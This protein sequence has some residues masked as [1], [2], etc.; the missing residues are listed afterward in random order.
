MCVMEQNQTH[1]PFVYSFTHFL[2]KYLEKAK[3][4][5]QASNFKLQLN[6]KNN[7]DSSLFLHI[8]IRVCLSG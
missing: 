5:F 8:R 6:H 1:L 4:I 2:Q 7:I 3:N